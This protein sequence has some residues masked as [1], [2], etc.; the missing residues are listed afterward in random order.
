MSRDSAG[1][2][3]YYYVCGKN[4][5]SV[6]ELTGLRDLRRISGGTVSVP[7]QS[8]VDAQERRLVEALRTAQ[9]KDYTV[10]RVSHEA[11]RKDG[12][13]ADWKNAERID[14]FALAYDNENLYVHFQGHESSR[15][16]FQNNG[17]NLLE[18]FRT[19]DVLDLMLQTRSGLSPGRREAGEGDIRLSFSMFEGEP[20]CVLYD[21]KV[22][23][24][25]G[26]PIPFGSPVR[27]IYCDSVNILEAAKVVVSRDRQFFTM[28]ATV[29]LRVIRLNPATLKETRGDV[30]R[31]YGDA[32]ATRAARREYWA[33]KNTHIMSD[34]PSEAM[35]QPSLWGVFR[36]E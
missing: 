17:V 5:C 2:E 4:H 31:I 26:D 12:Y 9:P 6:V 14:G 21:F 35:L 32:T 33:N 11:L 10:R 20:R 16:P 7:P 1:K 30:G 34:L 36:F 13:P 3:R 22:P 18:L 15:T 27:T 8:I 29:P 28:E 23:D 24:F 19:G 25:K